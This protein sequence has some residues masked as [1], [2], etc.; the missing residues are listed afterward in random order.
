MAP[1]TWQLVRWGQPALSS[2]SGQTLHSCIWNLSD[3]SKETNCGLSPTPRPCRS[4]WAEHKAC[5][6]NASKGKLKVKCWKHSKLPELPPSPVDVANPGT[7]W[8]GGEDGKPRGS[9]TGRPH[10]VSSSCALSH[11]LSA[12]LVLGMSSTYGARRK[13]WSRQSK[14]GGRVS[15]CQQCPVM[16]GHPTM[17]RRSDL[18]S[19]FFL[20]ASFSFQ[21]LHPFPFRTWPET[22]TNVTFSTQNTAQHHRT[23]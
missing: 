13:A 2:V 11:T 20:Q 1:L 10:T 16:S 9:T 7:R 15:S 6:I 23:R 3:A 8:G 14:S 5:I 18:I 4:P 17:V 19:C 12:K 22:V 21:T